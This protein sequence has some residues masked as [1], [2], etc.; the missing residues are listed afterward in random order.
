V[1]LTA[2]PHHH[3][4]A[5]ELLVRGVHEPGVAGLGEALALVLAAARA[6][7]VDQAGRVAG[8]CTVQPSRCSSTSNPA[9]VYSTPNRRQTWSATR[10]SVQH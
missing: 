1:T 3:E 9:S 2:V 6:D 7:A 5:A 10:A 8:T 4:R